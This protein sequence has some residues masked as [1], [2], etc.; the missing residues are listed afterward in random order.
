MALLSFLRALLAGGR[1]SSQ[2]SRRS[3]RARPRLEA[4]Q[5]RLAPAVLTVTNNLDDYS[6]GSL[7]SEIDAAHSGDVINFASG[8]QGKTIVLAQQ[9]LQIRTSLTISGPGADKLTISGA[10]AS[11]IFEVF[12]GA[13]LN[14]SGVTL[15]H[16]NGLFSYG[17]FDPAPHDGT[18]GAIVN[19]GTLTV[20]NCTLTGNTATNLGGAIFNAGTLTLTHSTVTSNRAGDGGGID[21]ATGATAEIL[22]GSVITGNTARVGADVLKAKGSTLKI[23]NDSTVGVLDKG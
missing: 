8:L 10:D 14:L 7:R 16:G 13:T 11:R 3:V 18:G 5:D 12:S 22:S 20:T 6:A 15:T 23:S 19:Y 9:E 21:N 4:L 2:S 17:Y 1:H